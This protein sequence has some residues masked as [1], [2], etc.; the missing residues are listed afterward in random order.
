MESNILARISP[1]AAQF[2]NPKRKRIYHKKQ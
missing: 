1:P 2:H